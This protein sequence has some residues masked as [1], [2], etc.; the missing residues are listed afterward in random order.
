MKKVFARETEI[1]RERQKYKEGVCE[2]NRDGERERKRQTKSK[3]RKH[4]GIIIKQQRLIN[5]KGN[6]GTEIERDKRAKKTERKINLDRE[7]KQRRINGK[8][9]RER[10]R[11]QRQNQLSFKVI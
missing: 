2:T 8:R 7:T 11:N 9:S 1:K 3:D 5:G 4:R 6:R 10:A